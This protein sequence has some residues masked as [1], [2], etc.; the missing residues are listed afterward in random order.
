MIIA[1]LVKVKYQLI[2]L[3]LLCLQ[4]FKDLADHSGYSVMD[5]Y[6]PFFDPNVPLVI[7]NMPCLS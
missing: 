3:G 4:R 2:R 1:N 6:T 5:H 7:L